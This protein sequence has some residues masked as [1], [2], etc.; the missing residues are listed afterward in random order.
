LLRLLSLTLTADSATQG[1]PNLELSVVQNFIGIL[2][3]PLKEKI[4]Q[5]EILL[6]F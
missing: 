1:E 3:I 6:A 2:E 5:S 4:A